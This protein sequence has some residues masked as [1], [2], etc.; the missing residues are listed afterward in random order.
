MNVPFVYK[1]FYNFAVNET[2]QRFYRVLKIIKNRESKTLPIYFSNAGLLKNRKGE[3]SDRVK[4]LAWVEKNL[5]C[6]KYT[7]K[8]WKFIR[9]TNKAFEFIKASYSIK[10]KTHGAAREVS[11]KTVRQKIS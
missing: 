1:S 6:G 3:N 9:D 7:S 5:C 10:S 11:M 8:P 4:S 2:N